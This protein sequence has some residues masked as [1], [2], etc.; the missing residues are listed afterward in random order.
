VRK[1]LGN[2]RGVNLIEMLMI[3]GILGVVIAG[4]MTTMNVGMATQRT[5]DV[6]MAVT[7]LEADVKSILSEDA[8]CVETLK[9]V[10]IHPFPGTPVRLTQ[11][12]EF[13]AGASAPRVNYE[14]NEIY[15]NRRLQFIELN[16]TGFTPN[17]PAPSPEQWRGVLDAAINLDGV[18]DMTGPRRFMRTFKLRV[19]LDPSTGMVVA[20]RFTNVSSA[21]S[22]RREVNNCGNAN[23]CSITCSGSSKLVSGGCRVTSGNMPIQE[24]YPASDN[25]WFCQPQAAAQVTAFAICSDSAVY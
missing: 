16:L 24:S 13:P 10:V 2:Q 1:I 18:G 23:S 5:V 22:L 6:R 9:N 11:I 17:V 25:S 12:R 8:S 7:N 14:A 3:T 19:E 15:D 20:C 4:I 21:L